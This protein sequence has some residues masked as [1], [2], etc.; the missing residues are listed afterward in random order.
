[1]TIKRCEQRDM[2][3]KRSAAEQKYCLFTKDG[4]R[5]LGRHETME[6]AQEQEAAIHAKGGST[7]ISLADQKGN[8]MTRQYIKLAEV[9]ESAV[10]SL[11]DQKWGEGIMKALGEDFP[12]DSKAAQ[13]LFFTVWSAVIQL[14]DKSL[15][16]QEVD[17]SEYSND[18]TFMQ[19]LAGLAYF[20]ADD[21]IKSSLGVSSDSLQKGK[22][23]ASA[24]MAVLG[25]EADVDQTLQG[26]KKQA[27]PIVEKA[28]DQV[29]GYLKDQ[30][31]QK[32]A[33]TETRAKAFVRYVQADAP[34][35]QSFIDNALAEYDDWFDSEA[36]DY[37]ARE[38][39]RWVEDWV[40][41]IVEATDDPHGEGGELDYHDIPVQLAEIL[42]KLDPD[43]EQEDHSQQS[44]YNDLKDIENAA[45]EAAYQ[46]AAEPLE[47]KTKTAEGWSK[48]PKGWTQESLKKFW[49]DLTGDRKHKVS[50]CIKKMEGKVDDPGAFCA[51][52]ADQM[53]EMEGWREEPRSS[54]T[55]RAPT[56]DLLN[57][58]DDKLVGD[59]VEEKVEEKIAITAEA[60]KLI[61]HWIKGM[62]KDAAGPATVWLYNVVPIKASKEKWITTAEAE[63]LYLPPHRRDVPYLR[64]H[65]QDQMNQQLADQLNRNT[66][67]GTAGDFVYTERGG[68]LGL[69]F[70][71]PAIEDVR[72]AFVTKAVKAYKP[73]PTKTAT[74]DPRT[75]WGRLREADAKKLDKVNQTKQAGCGCGRKGKPM[76]PKQYKAESG[77]VAIV[78]L[79]GPIWAVGNSCEEAL[80]QLN[81]DAGYRPGDD[82]YVDKQDL[83]AYM[84]GRTV[85]DELVC[86]PC[87]AECA[88]E[89]EQ[90]GGDIAYDIVDGEVV[91]VEDER[92]AA[93]E[94]KA[95][96]EGF[97]G[98]YEEVIE[99]PD[100]WSSMGKFSS[101]ADEVVYEWTLDGG[102][103]DFLGEAE[104]FGY[105]EL[106]EVPGGALVLESDG[107]EWAFEAAIMMVNNSGFVDVAY[108]DTIAEGRKEWEELENEYSL[109]L[110]EVDDP[111]YF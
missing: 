88:A 64:E 12:L 99:V 61:R 53:P 50:A 107:T 100:N 34:S 78:Q 23:H 109:F 110:D 111:D 33:S 89:V 59:Q 92:E 96:D 82:Q 71:T 42:F 7:N 18:P 39:D 9:P 20:V 21:A 2:D 31:E 102:G 75:T 91:L 10:Q 67:A 86:L 15:M 81:D 87:S 66:T 14:M 104:T 83:E 16:G 44:I 47:A 106:I 36:G 25:K 48:L 3:P 55:K 90:Y 108:F 26:L 49:S 1:M 95:A 101:Y 84:E 45:L 56:T 76:K 54:T 30:P 4:S 69:Q 37:Y 51:S 70:D 5:L 19:S 28:F 72:A 105:Y 8:T 77:Q 11:Y 73:T 93:T 52:L 27:E 103:S 43:W 32:A 63:G 58:D 29:T 97:Y 6:Q 46:G 60:D 38:F 41:L 80:A 65:L 79:C 68:Q 22:G 74:T 57:Q 94:R 85:C 24:L 13:F 35:V 98:R 62:P 40:Q 17:T